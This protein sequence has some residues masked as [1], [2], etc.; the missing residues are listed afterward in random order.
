MKE[1][2]R[3]QL[4]EEFEKHLG[5]FQRLLVLRAIRPDKVIPAVVEFVM[6]K[7]GKQFVEPPPFDLSRS[8]SD[9]SCLSPLIFILSPGANP[10]TA[11]LKFA[12][13]QVSW[14]Y[15]FHPSAN[16]YEFGGSH[17]MHMCS[18]IAGCCMQQLCM[19]PHG[20]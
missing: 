6:E 5:Q 12:D 17:L 4:P 3:A 19:K 14:L 13:D 9:S 1:P 18:C 8:F 10:T 20:K 11:L 15:I 2:H 7:I 16:S